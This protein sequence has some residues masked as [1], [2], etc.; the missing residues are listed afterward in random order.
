MLNA[1]SSP[2][3]WHE[4]HAAE[5]VPVVEGQLLQFNDSP[6]RVGLPLFYELHVWSWRENP[7]GTFVDWNPRVSCDGV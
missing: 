2:A 7:H 1:S 4:T 6:N 3:A 5:A